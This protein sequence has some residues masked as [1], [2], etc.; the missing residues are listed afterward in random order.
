MKLNKKITGILLVS[1]MMLTGVTS[2]WSQATLGGGGGGET[3]LESGTATQ[4]GFS[5][6]NETART[7]RNLPQPL[8][9]VLLL[10]DLNEILQ[11]QGEPVNLHLCFPAAGMQL[12]EMQLAQAA[13][14]G[15]AIGL[16]VGHRTVLVTHGPQVREGAVNVVVGTVDFAGKYLDPAARMNVKGSFLALGKIAGWRTGFVMVVTGLLPGDVDEVIL[17]LGV[18]RE[19]YP[20]AQSAMIKRVL[21][22]DRPPFLRQAPLNTDSLYTFKDLQDIGTNMRIPENGGLEMEIFLPA[23]IFT[24]QNVEF[25]FKLHCLIGQGA[26]R[27]SGEMMVMVGDKEVLRKRWSE[28]ESLGDGG[29]EL[30][31]GVPMNHFS[32]GINKVTFGAATLDSD[33]KVTSLGMQ[34]MNKED[35]RIYSDS[36]LLIPPVKRYVPLP[37]LLLTGKTF[38]PFI[39]Q[40]DGSEISVLLTEETPDTVNAAITFLTKAAQQA[41][42]FF[43]AAQIGYAEGGT[44]RHRIVIGTRENLPTDIRPRIPLT[45]LTGANLQGGN[46]GKDELKKLDAS[47][48]PDMGLLTTLP[49]STNSGLWTLI[50]T[51]GS[52]ASLNLRTRELVSAP[53]WDQLKGEAA[54]WKTDETLMQFK[55]PGVSRAPNTML[56]VAELPFGYRMYFKYWLFLVVVVLLVFMIAS[57]RVLKKCEMIYNA[58]TGGKA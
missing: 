52:P 10:S 41:N 30:V 24:E 32:P 2:G 15:Q 28:A 35:F 33:R 58:R 8:P 40:P 12:S 46:A 29:S 39:G 31:F 38:F 27:S 26:L 34:S 17:S 49:P 54:A 55:L 57:W 9:D 11:M 18:V 21:L 50:L 36:I 5:G 6:R 1:G 44:K 43:Y 48:D 37:D 42:T 51:S 16:R 14:I 7:R 4:S 45:P 19:K 47:S 3:T 53:F 22:P 13:A 56:S 23:D 20:K 25:E